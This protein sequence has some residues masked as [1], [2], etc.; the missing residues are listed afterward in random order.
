M[1][2]LS[3]VLKCSTLKLQSVLNL[4]NP[5]KVRCASSLSSTVCVNVLVIYLL[6][7]SHYMW[8]SCNVYWDYENQPDQPVVA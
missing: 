5:L 6:Q 7:F 1:S 8:L 3:I 2:L 4:C